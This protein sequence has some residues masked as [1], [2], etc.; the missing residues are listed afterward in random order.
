M[1][2]EQKI[3][4]KLNHYPGIKKRIKRLYQFA[5][6]ALLPKIKSQGMRNAEH[7]VNHIMLSPNGKRF[8]ILHRWL[9][10][11]RKYTRLLTVN[12]DGSDMYNLSDDD[13]VSH[14]YWKNDEEILAF[15]NK[16]GQGAGYYLMR[17]K[18][19]EYRRSWPHIGNDG[20]P[21]YSPDGKLVLTDTYP[22]RRRMASIKILNDDFN[23]VIA[24]VFAPF[25][26]DNDTRCDLHPRWS[27]DGKRVYF[28]AVFEGHRGLYMVDVSNIKFAHSETTGSALSFRAYDRKIRIVYV[29]TSCR[30]SG[31]TQVVM[32]I[33]KYL[34]RS[35]FEPIL[36]TIY[37]ETSTSQIADFLPYISAHYLVKTGKKDVILGHDSALRKKL[38]ELNPDVIHSTGAFP[39][40]AIS[41]ISPQ[42][43]IITL[44]SYMYADYLTRFGKIICAILI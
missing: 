42:K 34:D 16:N 29:M 41:R 27:R 3:N 31:P 5:I 15:E 18:S 36:V 20:H 37:D 43:Q 23:I 14:C 33:L 8:M 22:D 21:S 28:D 1:S 13:M 38:E 9:D 4:Q 30:K 44:H 25:K 40:Y 39:Y 35:I 2:I 10:G 24:K 19:R 32:N 11:Q 12:A 7:K 6:Y 26:Y 17:D